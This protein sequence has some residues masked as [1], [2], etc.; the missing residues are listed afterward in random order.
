MTVPDSAQLHLSG[1]ALQ[2]VDGEVAGLATGGMWENQ[3]AGTGHFLQANSEG[4]P[5]VESWLSQT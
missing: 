2:A 4:C 3:L 1:T 5:H